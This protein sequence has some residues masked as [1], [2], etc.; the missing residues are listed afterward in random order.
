MDW[1][2]KLFL[3]GFLALSLGAQNPQI[4]VNQSEFTFG[5]VSALEPLKA[6]FKITNTGTGYLNITELRPSCGCTATMLKEWS[7]KPSGSAVLEV[8][9]NPQGLSG[10]ISKSI[11]VIS[12][13][14]S[15]SPMVLTLVA[16]IIPMVI[17]SQDAIY[18]IRLKSDPRQEFFVR[19]TPTRGDR[20]TISN[21]E[22]KAE[23]LQATWETKDSSLVMKIAL[24]G[25][26]LPKDKP[27]GVERIIIR[28]K[29]FDEWTQI[30][31][32]VWERN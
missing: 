1:F 20:L 17:A 4:T 15:R 10:S 24:D 2:K 7:I 8:T 19:F 6:L 30:F 22:I 26:R 27:Y 3:F 31:N 18:P 11:N 13:D 12:N 32:V 9:L 21:V 23:W 25:S 14:S 16:E 28:F 29:E 5:K